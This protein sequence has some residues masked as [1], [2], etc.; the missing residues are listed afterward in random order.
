MRQVDLRCPCDS[1]TWPQRVASESVHECESRSCRPGSCHSGQV[2]PA[3]LVLDVQVVV[4]GRDVG[5][6]VI[7]DEEQGVP[8][9]LLAHLLDH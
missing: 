8:F 3:K 6:G 1:G 5:F 7:P 2:L 9:L 4:L